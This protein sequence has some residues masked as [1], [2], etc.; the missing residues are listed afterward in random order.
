MTLFTAFQLRFHEH[1]ETAPLTPDAKR[2]GYAL[3]AYT[4]PGTLARCN[5]KDLQKATGLNYTRTGAAVHALRAARLIANRQTDSPERTG[6][7]LLLP[8]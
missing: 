5:W 7:Q 2:V 3:T 8:R 1:I 6:W 4:G